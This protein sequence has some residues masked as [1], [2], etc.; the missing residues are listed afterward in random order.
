MAK[1]KLDAGSGM[2]DSKTQGYRDTIQN[3]EL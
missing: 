3:Y 1:L 2:L